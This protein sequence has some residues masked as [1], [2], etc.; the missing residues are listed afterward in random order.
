MHG[1]VLPKL[2]GCSIHVA[3]TLE[4]TTIT[5][6]GLYG[7]REGLASRWLCFNGFIGLTMLA[8]LGDKEPRSIRCC[9]L[10]C[11]CGWLCCVDVGVLMLL[12][13]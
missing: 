9:S 11:H 13:M 5:M 3:L 2:A 12:L 7:A 8:L 1:P 10:D 6:L 4:L